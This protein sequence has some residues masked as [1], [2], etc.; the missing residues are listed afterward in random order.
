[1]VYVHKVKSLNLFD[2]PL[3]TV[4]RRYDR[5]RMNLI[6]IKEAAMKRSGLRTLLTG[7]LMTLFFVSTVLAAYEFYM[8]K[9]TAKGPIDWVLAAKEIGSV[10]GVER[11]QI[12]QEKGVVT[13]TCSSQCG[14]SILNGVKNK[15]KAKGIEQ[16]IVNKRASASEPGKLE[17][18]KGEGAIHKVDKIGTG[19]AQK[20]ESEGKL[21]PKVE[22]EGKL[23]P[24][25]ENQGK[26]L[27][28]NK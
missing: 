8:V 19:P 25:I 12:D 22:S 28:Q 4:F 7:I 20:Y 18:I 26:I 3:L 23:F 17:I 1:M 15:L 10:K 9:L 24:K 6:Y 16:T 11:T 14:D 5:Y 21:F 13:I 27:P 2:S